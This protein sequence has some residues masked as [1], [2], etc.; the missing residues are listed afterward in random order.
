MEDLDVNV[1]FN[2]KVTEDLIKQ[3]KPEVLIIATGSTEKK[4]NVP[5][6]EKDKVS[7][8]VEVLNGTKKTGKNVL[9]VGGGLVGCET[10]L[11]LAQ[12]GKNVTVVE[13]L[14]NI[15][16]AGKPVPHMNKIML[17]DLMDQHNVK[18]ITS[19]CLLEVTD[20]G[21]ILIDNKFRK[22]TV[23]A[24][25]IVLSVGF[26]SNNALYEKVHNEVDDVYL[27]GDAENASNIM[28]AVWTANEIALNV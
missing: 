6:I 8:A 18:T 24:D 12:E 5:G 2:T 19:N 26:S 4:L 14:D 22:Q 10:A 20:D 3:K 15:L 23:E 27:V 11:W 7:T 9:M 13:A 28:D 21:A 17:I 1:V 25:S 16:S